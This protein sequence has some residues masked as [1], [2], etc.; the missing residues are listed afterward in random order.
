MLVKN[1]VIMSVCGITAIFFSISLL[2]VY[3]NQ[4]RLQ[5]Q[6]EQ[7]QQKTVFTSISQPAPHV[8]ENVVTSAQL[9]RPVQ[10]RVR[11][12]VVQLFVQLSAVDLLE[13][14]KTPQQGSACGS[15]FFINDEG[16]L[17]TNA[18]VVISAKTVWG[19]IP[20]LGKHIIDMDVIGMSPERDLALL[21]VTAEGRE[22][23]TKELGGIPYLPLGDSD[24]VRRSDDVL[25]L[26]YPLGQQSFKSTN[27]IISG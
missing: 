20:S 21:R 22:L 23:I 4:L 14:Y 3:K 1:S 7:S 27:G 9:W 11:D 12:T 26:G 25:A 2:Y 8:T 24:L 18:H 15:G 17:I 6:W 5:N 13:P 19:Q 16:Y 10:E